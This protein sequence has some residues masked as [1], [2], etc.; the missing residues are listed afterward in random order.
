MI[1]PTIYNFA[2]TYPWNLLVSEKVTYFL[3]IPIVFTVQK[4]NN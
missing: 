4:L 1:T 3:T 2:V